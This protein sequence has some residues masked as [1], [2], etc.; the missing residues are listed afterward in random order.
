MAYKINV[1]IEYQGRFVNPGDVDELVG[2]PADDL[3]RFVQL[4]TIEV[5]EAPATQ[6][7]PADQPVEASRSRR[8][9]KE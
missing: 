8:P 9:T 5:V 7:L 6:N 1:Q 3:E 2:W 4:G